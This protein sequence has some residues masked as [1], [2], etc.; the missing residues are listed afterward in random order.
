M[1]DTHTHIY[2][3]QFSEDREALLQ[4][5]FEAGVQELFLPNIDKESVAAL[6][7]LAA[8][9]DHIYPMM[10]LHPSH[11]KA[12]YEEELAVVWEELTS[13]THYYAVGEIGID[14]YWD[15]TFIKEQQIAFDLQIS[16][17]K[18]MGLPIVIHCRDAFDETFE[19]LESHRGDDLFGIFHCF[20]GNLDQAHQALSLNLKL[21]IGGVV[22][23]KNGG[24]DKVVAELQT[25]DLVLETDAPYLAPMPYRGKRNEPAYLSYIAQKIADL[26]ERPL[27]EVDAI[28]TANARK[29]FQL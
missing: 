8:D 15:K 17:A 4:R 25:E 7:K 1:I 18:E 29:I 22:T 23:F 26:H 13:D 2:L 6:K 16:K 12:D 20:T 3:K 11:V 27:E 19:V 10:G 28:T 21:G 9:H 5:A 24:L 14:L